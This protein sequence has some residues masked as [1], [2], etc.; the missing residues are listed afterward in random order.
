MAFTR[1]LKQNDFAERRILK[2]TCKRKIVFDRVLFD[3]M[4]SL[5]LKK[6]ETDIVSFPFLFRNRSTELTVNSFFFDS[7]FLTGKS[8]QVV[9]LSA[10]DFTHFVH[11]D[12]V[13][14]R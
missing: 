4:R 11:F 12:A 10:T 1:I 6:R 2:G 7:C 13:D 3:G 14:S 9:Q 5:L 8:A